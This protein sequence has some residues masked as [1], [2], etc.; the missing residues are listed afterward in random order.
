MPDTC[1]CVVCVFRVCVA[2]DVR[3]HAYACVYVVL[4]AVAI[5]MDVHHASI[6]FVNAH[7]AAH[8]HKYADR[9]RMFEE[10]TTG[11]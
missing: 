11:E 10:I 9:N 3:C 4:G 7:L 1:V 5:S 2:N 6:C 8:M